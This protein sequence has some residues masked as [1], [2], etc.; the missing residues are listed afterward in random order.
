M[1][2]EQL[3]PF[4]QPANLARVPSTNALSTVDNVSNDLLRSSPQLT[5]DA[6]SLRSF[7]LP[8]DL[9]PSRVFSVFELTLDSQNALGHRKRVILC[10]NTY[11]HSRRSSVARDRMSMLKNGGVIHGSCRGGHISWGENAAV[12]QIK[13]D[14]ILKVHFQS[15]F[16]S[17]DVRVS[18]WCGH[19]WDDPMVTSRCLETVPIEHKQRARKVQLHDR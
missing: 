7:D 19:R 16:R 8:R 17:N 2:A 9:Q 12:V 13:F 1:F 3:S 10:W 5:E 4:F 18:R 14:G 11:F 15:L 6:S